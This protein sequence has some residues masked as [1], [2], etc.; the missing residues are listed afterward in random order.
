VPRLWADSR[1]DLVGAP[2]D[3]IADTSG[4]REG[5]RG[6]LGVQRDR[7]YGLCRGWKCRHGLR[8]SGLF[9]DGGDVDADAAV[10]WIE[11]EEQPGVGWVGAWR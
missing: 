4:P 1:D 2:L 5:G 9:A 10:I 8:G 3:H 6:G 11:L 7:T